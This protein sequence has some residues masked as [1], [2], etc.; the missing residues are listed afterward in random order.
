MGESVGHVRAGTLLTCLP[1]GGE[2][3]GW[4]VRWR[5]LSELSRGPPPSSHR[6]VSVPTSAMCIC[7]FPNRKTYVLKDTSMWND[8]NSVNLFHMMASDAWS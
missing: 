7:Q 1:G 6:R 5:E 3:L 2:G 4:G 8:Y